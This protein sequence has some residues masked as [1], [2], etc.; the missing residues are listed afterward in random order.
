MTVHF[1]AFDDDTSK[2]RRQ[3]ASVILGE[4]FRASGRTVVGGGFN[5]RPA[6]ALRMFSGLANVGG[7]QPLFTADASAVS[8]MPQYQGFIDHIWASPNLKLSPINGASSV[9]VALDKSIQ[10]YTSLVSD[11]R[12]IMVRLAHER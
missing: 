9:V 3:L 1:K 2:R 11:H 7:L 10:Q 6:D 5:A 8:S 4:I 12:P